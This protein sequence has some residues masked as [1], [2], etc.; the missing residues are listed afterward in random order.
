MDL[1]WSGEQEAIFEAARE[2]GREVVAPSSEERDR[3]SRFDHGIWK[4]LAESGFW[5]AGV[6]AELGGDG[7]GLANYVAALEGL[8]LGSQDSG[9]SVTV[10]A[11]ASLI[12]V[13]SRWGTAEQQQRFLPDL[14]AGHVG[15]TA[16]TEL[17]GG[18]HVTAVR[19]TAEPTG[20]G[21][22]TLSGSKSHITNAPVADMM[23][24]VGRVA[25]LGKR[26]ISLFLLDRGQE[27]VSLGENE[28]LIGLR[29]SPIGPIDMDRVHIPPERVLG[30]VGDGLT[31]LYWCLA[32]D[33]LSFGVIASAQMRSMIPRAL[34]RATSRE[35][36]GAPIAEYQYIQDK[37][38]QMKV[39]AET[40]RALSYATLSAMENGDADAGTL[41]S[42]TKLAS[43]Q[44]IV[45]SSL[46]LVQLFGHMGYDRTQG[47]E[48]HLRDAAAFRIAGG[49]DEM[50]KKAIFSQL[51]AA[52][53]SN[54]L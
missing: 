22:Y 14:F 54:S 18:S 49:T 30:S 33:R 21:H 12:Q 27:G 17:T 39:G 10:G 3:A 43:A 51:L 52:S 6:P 8:T 11:H 16:A 7:G 25:G 47:V 28:D 35:A 46:E 38:V 1:R 45:G 20:D 53:R 37:I 26:D 34:D 4:A 5:K 9:F 41:A 40:A 23:L 48:R 31:V 44:A 2:F 24:I 29:T 15:A 13:L 19:T 32:L 50:Q 42:C 36:F